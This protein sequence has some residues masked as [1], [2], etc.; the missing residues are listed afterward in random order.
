MQ[1]YDAVN[2]PRAFEKVCG[3]FADVPAAVLRQWLERLVLD[4]LVY[5]DKRTDKYLGVAVRGY[6]SM[7]EYVTEMNAVL[8]ARPEGAT[9]TIRPKTRMTLPLLSTP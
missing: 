3:R 8:A 9:P 6:R 4:R 1:V 7:E 5:H 2:E